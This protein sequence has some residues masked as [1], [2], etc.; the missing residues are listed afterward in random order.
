M[1]VRLRG[2]GAEARGHISRL[3]PGAFTI[4]EIMLAIMI[5]AMVLT[6]IYSSWIAILRGTKAGEK[7]AAEVQRSRIAISAM[8]DAFNC[9]V[10]YVENNKWYY[11][12]ADSGGDMAGVSMVSR[13]PAS[14]PGVGRYGDQ[15]VR[16]VSFY[17]QPGKEGGQELVMSQ[18]PMLLDTNSSSTG[19]YS[20]V[21][22]RDVSLFSL[23]FWDMRQ[24]DWVSEW[25]NTNQLPRMVRIT[26]GL[27]RV[28]GNASKPQDLVSR[29]VALPSIS[30]AGVQSAPGIGYPGA[31]GL[32]PG[33]VP[34]G[35]VPPGGFP[36]GAGIPP[37]GVPPGYQP[38]FGPGQ[39]P[40][41]PNGPR[42]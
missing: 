11:F 21:L 39:N 41:Y 15:I 28:G 4:I 35:S 9:A 3:V 7:A 17:T 26:L 30:V 32:P 22:A 29:I 19:P 13:L 23:E 24:N 40:Y 27:G 5:F 20:L 34:P 31:P 33:A 2:Q 10:M 14:F 16:R 18:V 37:G 38:G 1:N 12:V 42:R 8:E 25:N 6:A 36:G